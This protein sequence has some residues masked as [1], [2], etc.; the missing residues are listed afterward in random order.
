[1]PHD[2]RTVPVPAS[3]RT[4][5]RL[6]PAIALTLLACASAE[7][8][9]RQTPTS[10]GG[11]VELEPAPAAASPRSARRQVYVCASPELVEF[12]DRPC[13]PLATLHELRLRVPG[14]LPH[15][16][17][18]SVRPQAPSVSTRRVAAAETSQVPDDPAEARRAETCTRLER[19]VRTLDD[20]MRAGYGARDAAR[21]WAQWRE[22]KARLRDAECR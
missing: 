7:P 20:R 1:M 14:N 10:G 19:A 21:L 12:S 9:A 22:A 11:S 15:G 8:S 2:L 4:P 16:A 18:A 3:G 5:A 17:V 6:L 13:G